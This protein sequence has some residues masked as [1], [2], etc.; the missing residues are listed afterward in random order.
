MG[1]F[2]M[3]KKKPAPVPAPEP[4][5]EPKPEPKDEKAE[6][7]DPGFKTYDFKV[8]GVAYH[9]ESLIDNIV[10][11][12]DDYFMKKSELIELGMVNERIYKYEPSFMN[13]E[14]VPDP[15]NEH[16]PNAIKVI[17]DGVHIGFVPEKK[18]A[19]VKKI[20]DKSEILSLACGI[21]GGPYRYIKE[22][23]DDDKDKDVYEEEKGEV[24][25]FAD[26]SIN[27]K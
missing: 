15:T 5:P 20:L 4:A 13:V 9:E 2:D 18:T 19:K 7:P 3:F 24:H 10:F 21:S 23:Y 25:F 8:A 27:Y 12:N 6:K 11:E 14:L 22:Y 17:V 1:L 26:I 16:D